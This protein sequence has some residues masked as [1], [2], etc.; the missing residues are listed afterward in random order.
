[1][2]SEQS[3][4]F[5]ERLSQWVASQGFWFQI[6][7]SMTGSGTGGTAM[8][9]LLRMGFQLLIFLLVVAAGGWVYLEK[10]S[11]SEKFRDG[12]SDRLKAGLYASEIDMKGFSRAQGELTLNHLVCQGG[13]ESF[14]SSL[15]A[16]NIHCKMG[17][18]DGV[19]GHWDTGTIAISR[20]D[21]EVR[22]GA[23]DAESAKMLSKAIFIPSEKVTVNAVDVS[24]A[25]LRW[26]YSEKTKGS[27]ENSVMKLQRQGDGWK[28]SFRGG[29]F[30]QNWLRNLEIVNLVITCDPEGL[31]FEK[32]ELRSGQGTVDFSGLKVTGGERPTVEGSAKVRG[33][34]LQNTLSAAAG[35]FVEG[36][37]SGTFKISGSTNS[38][39]GVGFE[40][41][42]TLDDQDVVTLRDRIYLLNA[43]SG[44]DYVRN[45]HR[46][47]L[48]EG[49]FHLKTS[50]GGMLLTDVSLKAGDLFT[51]EG[52][53]RVRLAT[54]EET[55][56]AADKGPA[57]GG[58]SVF[59][60]D[61]DTRDEPTLK[62]LDDSDITLRRAAIA[63]KNKG[64]NPDGSV[65]LFDRMGMALDARQLE[66]Q[67]A[68]RLSRTLRYEGLFKVSIPPDAFDTA[69]KLL[70]QYPINPATNRIQLAVPIEG[71]LY[72]ITLKQGEDIYQ[73]REGGTR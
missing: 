33:L 70:A 65:S 6:R 57:A 39:E 51:L 40:G 27:I 45:Y 18:L 66:A 73:S 36:S 37:I 38:S 11:D 68:E 10:M 61:D 59:G 15:E 22:A 46:V 35:K 14:Y 67:A 69:P 24:D 42:V 55:K 60:N 25:S 26:G 32:A 20:L 8:F 9:H 1:M 52:N 16:K 2:E 56:D 53:M 31:V 72:E 64:A 47:D 63:A 44:V 17:L 19:T 28:M 54:P 23:D 41:Q 29:T 3:Q 43:L 5:N 13:G 62:K 71:S 30:S 21:M 50:G 7:Y 12:L 58:A 34:S 48:K 49:S 4:N